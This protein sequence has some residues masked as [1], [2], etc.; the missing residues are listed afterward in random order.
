[1]A[2]RIHQLDSL[3]ID[4]IAAG[5][6]IETP[7]SCIK[8]LIDNAID[9]D[10]HSICIEIRLGGRDQIIVRDDGKGM[11]KEDLELSYLRHATSKI[12]FIEDLDS[13]MTLGFR[14]E[15][16]SSIAAISKMTIRSREREEE[17]IGKGHVV[18]IEGGSFLGIKEVV[19]PIGTEVTVESLFFNVPARRKFLKS[20]AQNGVEVLKVVKQFA[21]IA[22]H[23][24]ITLIS[25]GKEVFQTSKGQSF[26]ERIKEVQPDPFFRHALPLQYQK[27]GIRID[28]L[29]ALP[30]YAKK[31]RSGQQLFVNNRPVSSHMVSYTVRSAYSTAL[32][33][34]MN[35]QFVL[36]L[37][38]DPDRI[39]VNVHP[40]K[41]EIR[42][43]DEEW[44]RRELYEAVGLALF[45]SPSTTLKD[46]FSSIMGEPSSYSEEKA[47]N[48]YNPSSSFSF[49][50]PTYAE[51]P[52]W[53]EEKIPLS[54]PAPQES[55][56]STLHIGRYALTVL[57]GRPLLIDL[58]YAMQA[59]LA[60]SLKQEKRTS[61][62]L[63]TPEIIELNTLEMQCIEEKLEWFRTLGFTLSIFGKNSLLMEGIPSF[64]EPK[65]SS[66][67]I[68]EL[69][70]QELVGK[71][72]SSTT[73]LEQLTLTAVKVINL[74]EEAIDHS[75]VQTILDNWMKAGSPPCTLS[76][77]KVYLPLAPSLLKPLFEEA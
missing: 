38:L 9:A 11:G 64:L 46:T 62:L 72:L 29:L 37:T 21:L 13:L 48:S 57:Q 60:T 18:T 68:K 52:L 19:A 1:M 44:V 27:Q 75:S 55:S 73:L 15:A 77:K 65:A 67:Y 8:E 23:V 6:V 14:G 76:G 50:Q 7:A 36:A 51:H 41:K 45:A 66:T 56:L 58:L 69:I 17:M 71:E 28:G 31:N 25:D 59:T 12:T 3:T 16:L 4:K 63:L 61:S 43:A 42:F 34:D 33:S 70:D 74:N 39:D 26:I 30:E 47:P 2:P 40:Q 10:A 49:S 32:S 35:P 24:S 22:P 5:E 54:I 20:P 53:Q